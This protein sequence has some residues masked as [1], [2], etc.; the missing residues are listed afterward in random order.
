M[1]RIDI[2]HIH[3]GK[4]MMTTLD[5]SSKFFFQVSTKYPAKINGHLACDLPMVDPTV[6]VPFA[7]QTTSKSDVARICHI[8]LRAIITLGSM[9][10]QSLPIDAWIYTLWIDATSFD[11]PF[12]RYSLR[13]GYMKQHRDSM[14]LHHLLLLLC[15]T[16]MLLNHLLL[17][18]S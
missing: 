13:Q 15:S 10:L 16:C 3:I 8:A 11:C 2:R 18:L 12:A 6:S 7:R 5:M 17:W 4:V 1:G 9:S 14:N